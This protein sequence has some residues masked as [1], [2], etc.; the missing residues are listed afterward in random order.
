MLRGKIWHKGWDI[1]TRYEIRDDTTIWLDNAHGGDL[2]QVDCDFF[3]TTASE[4]PEAEQK[5]LAYLGQEKENFVFLV[6]QC[7]R[8]SESYPK[9]ITSSIT[10]AQE[11]IKNYKEEEYEY[12]HHWTVSKFN[13]NKPGIIE[14]VAFDKAGE[15]L[16]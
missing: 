10:Q 6:E 12:W 9:L 11:Y 8:F 13:L 4:D 16:V 15:L 7:L 1:P 14:T 2:R 5:I 3:L